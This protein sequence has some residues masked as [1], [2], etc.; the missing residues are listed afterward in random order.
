MKGPRWVVAVGTALSVAG[1]LAAQNS[2][3]GVRGIGFPTRPWSVHTR[4]LGG[5]WGIFDPLSAVNPA[6]VAGLTALTVSASYGS[7]FRSY[8]ASNTNVSGLRENRFPHGLIGGGVGR[9]RVSFALSYSTYAERTF[10]F[11]ETDSVMVRGNPIEVRDRQISDGGI[12][13]VRAALAWRLS[14]RVQFGGAFHIINGSSQISAAREF[15]NSSF[16]DFSA[17]SVVSFSGWGV[18]AGVTANFARRSVLLAAVVRRD[19]RL[20]STVDSSSRTGAQLP[21]M[22][23]A[24]VSLVLNP[25]ARWTT[26]LAWRSWSQAASGVTGPAFNTIEV[27]SG[28]ELGRPDSPYPLR[29][30]V[31]YATLPFTGTTSQAHEVTLSAGSGFRFAQQRATIFLTGERIFRDGGG[32]SER[33]WHLLVGLSVTP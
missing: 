30:G 29:V 3:Y 2:I 21:W 7:T 24:G 5:S 22:L 33:A 27:G 32:A 23:G 26:S 18:S 19:S 14:T 11:T 15:V 1:P 25:A 12:T 17:A 9:S 20:T 10:D 28:I 4:A 6:A 8:R 31:R 16:R 13:D